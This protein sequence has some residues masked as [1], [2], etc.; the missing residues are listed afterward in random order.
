MFQ[1][2]EE[3]QTQLEALD[4]QLRKLHTSIE[5]L[6]QYRKGEKNTSTFNPQASDII[7]IIGKN[8]QV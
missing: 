5:A 6:V 3:K 7:S 2:F 1:W 8:L 4:V